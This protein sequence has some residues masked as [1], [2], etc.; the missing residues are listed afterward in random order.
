[1]HSSSICKNSRRD[2]SWSGLPPSQLYW[3]L[4][5]RFSLGSRITLAGPPNLPDHREEQWVSSKPSRSSD[6]L[7]APVLSNLLVDVFSLTKI[8]F[9]N[10]HCYFPWS[11]LPSSQQSW[12]KRSAV[13]PWSACNDNRHSWNRLV[14]AAFKTKTV[15]N[16]VSPKHG[17]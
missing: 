14:H 16:E 6:I 17:G 7:I 4:K 1:M 2:L 15:G 12:R 13:P 9:K 10:F 5:T 8:A 3:K 11:G